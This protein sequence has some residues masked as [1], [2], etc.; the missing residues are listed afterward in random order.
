MKESEIA[1]L[2]AW[3]SKKSSVFLKYT[4]SEIVSNAAD[5]K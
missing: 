2:D 5:E 4:P 3:A 1:S